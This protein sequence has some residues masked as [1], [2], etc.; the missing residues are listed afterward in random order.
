MDDALDYY[1]A[2][3]DIEIDLKQNNE[4]AYRLNSIAEIYWRR[5]MYVDAL[6]YLRESETRVE[7]IDE[8]SETARHFRVLGQV[9]RARGQ[10]DEAVQAFLTAIPAFEHTPRI[11]GL[12]STRCALADMYIAQGRF[13]EAL[14]VI[15]EGLTYF[16][17]Q[18]GPNMAAMKL[19]HAAFLI[20]MGDYPGAEEE[21]NAVHHSS[22]A[23]EL[24]S[25]A[26]SEYVRGLLLA[27]TRHPAADEHLS[28]AV[29]AARQE[30]DLWLSGVSSIALGR[31]MVGQG[32]MERGRKLLVATLE[33]ARKAGIRPVQASAAFA[34]AET[35]LALGR[36][37][38]AE[39][40]LLEGKMLAESYQ[41]RILLRS[42]N[43]AISS[44]A[45]DRGDFEASEKASREAHELF[46]WARAQVPAPHVARFQ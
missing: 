42:I 35:E 6:V 13:R 12:A 10:Y 11:S 26:F 8:P 44:L 46:E 24:E 40:L 30:H 16:E 36:H 22:S 25:P 14:Q 21:L 15:E 41:G 23:R 3:L 34:V 19:S 45:R 43:Q 33:E 9:Q 18:S 1:R 5:G 7:G 17:K 37:K 27:A 29:N 39:E 38:A 32:S 2:S 31:V 28:R 20:E 4:I